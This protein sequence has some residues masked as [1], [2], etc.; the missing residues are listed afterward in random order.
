MATYNTVLKKRNAA[1]TE[2]DNVLPIT[3]AENVL[4]DQ[5]GGT[6]AARMKDSIYRTATGTATTVLVGIQSTLVDGFS[7]TFIASG[8]NNEAATTLNGKPLYVPGT[9]T[10]PKLVGGQAYTVWYSESGTCFFYHG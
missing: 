7:F 4:I 6:V 9:T 10:A 8:A 1:D 5:E 2:W 3:L